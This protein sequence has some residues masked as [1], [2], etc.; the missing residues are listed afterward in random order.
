MVADI[1]KAFHQ[2]KIAPEDRRMVRFLWFDDPSKERPEIQKYQFCRLVFGLVS[3]PAILTSVLQHHLAVNEEKEPKMVSLLRKSFYVEHF[4][5]GAF[6]DNEAG[7]VYEKS[8]TLMSSV[9]FTLRKWHTN[10]KHLQEEIATDRAENQHKGNDKANNIPG[11]DQEC[12]TRNDPVK[13]LGIPWNVD[14]DTLFHDYVKWSK[15]AT[16]LPATKRSV[17][18]LSAEIF[19][20]IGLLTP[21]TIKM[22]VFFQELCL[23]KVD[24][25]DELR[26]ELLEKWK[27]LVH[28]L[29]SLKDIKVPRCYFTRK[30]EPPVKHELHGFSDASNKAFAAVVYLRTEHANGDIE[31]NPVASK[32]RVAPIKRQ[33]IPRLELL[34]ATILVRLVKSVKEAM[35]SLKTPPEVFLWSDSCTVL[36]C[37]RN[38][39]HGSPIFKTE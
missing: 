9:G 4:A 15:D 30:E 39:K 11:S 17:L 31:I 23:A 36:C 21:F 2:V 20:P 1:E 35:S 29:N 37:I 28:N 26:G 7:E 38:D 34:G 19:D 8:Q 25:D 6:D 3:S 13:V 33:S 10:S 5:G 14:E 27:R 32:T 22:K 18:Q 12:K 24:W 16:T